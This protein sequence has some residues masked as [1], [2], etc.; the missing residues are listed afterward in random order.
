LTS[1]SD[2]KGPAGAPPWQSLRSA[3]KELLES[4][5]YAFIQFK[6][7]GDSGREGARLACQAVARFI[8]VRHENPELAAPLLAV[9][10]ALLDFDR[11]VQTELLATEPSERSRSGL[12]AHLKRVASA[13]LEVLVKNGEGLEIAARRVAR[14]VAKWPNIGEQQIT[15]TTIENWREAERGRPP[16][17]ARNHFDKLCEHILSLDDPKAEI[18]RLLRD[19]PPD[20]PKSQKYTPDI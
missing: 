16:G 6:S 13:C 12:K 9:H 18:E 11:G 2:P 1:H 19:G 20:A 10:Q 15:G 17:N 4:L 5:Y 3:N 14:A 8:A 7:K